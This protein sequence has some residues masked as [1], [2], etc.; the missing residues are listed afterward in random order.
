MF[1]TRD[2]SFLIIVIDDNLLKVDIR[3]VTRYTIKVRAFFGCVIQNTTWEISTIQ[4]LQVLN[5]FQCV[6]SIEGQWKVNTK[7][8]KSPRNV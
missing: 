1:G 4:T 5:G 6:H 2:V 7:L 8:T 3:S